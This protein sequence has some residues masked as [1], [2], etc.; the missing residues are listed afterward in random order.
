MFRDLFQRSF[1][2][3]LC[4]SHVSTD[5][6]SVYRAHTGTCNQILLKKFDEIRFLRAV[7]WELWGNLILVCI[8]EQH[9]FFM[10][11]TFSPYFCHMNLVWN[12]DEWPVLCLGHFNPFPQGR[13]TRDI[14]WSEV[15]GPY[16]QFICS[17][18]RSHVTTDRQS[19]RMQ[20][21]QARSETCDQML[22]SVR[23][24]LSESCCHDSW[25]PS[26]W[27]KHVISSGTILVLWIR[28][29]DLSADMC[30]CRC[31]GP[32][33][34]ACPCRPILQLAYHEIVHMCCVTLV[35]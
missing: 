26:L 24:L 35:R 17:R 30:G 33:W 18:S 7:N 21:C 34:D 32:R 1:L 10:R 3:S 15:S 2:R 6:Q 14:Q 19:S 25:A 5:G 13:G 12:A 27:V 28:E 31:S 8:N 20:R 22:L 9:Y 16:S 11:S 23:R 29:I 4:R